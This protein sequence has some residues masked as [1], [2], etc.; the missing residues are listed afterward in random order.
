MR[1]PPLTLEEMTP[2]QREVAEAISNRRAGALC[3][4][5]LPRQSLR[6]HGLHD[7]DP[8][9]YA[10]VPSEGAGQLRGSETVCSLIRFWHVSF[11]N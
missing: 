4:P 10:N 3:G 1:Y 11:M 2:R 5:Y 8:Q 9:R 7:N 6:L